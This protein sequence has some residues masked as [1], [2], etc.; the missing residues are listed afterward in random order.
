MWVKNERL[1]GAIHTFYIGSAIAAGA[2][3]A[4]WLFF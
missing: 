4:W 3:L 1:D 2:L